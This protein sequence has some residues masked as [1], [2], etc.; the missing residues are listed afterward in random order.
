MQNE[1]KKLA[2]TD[3]QTNNRKVEIQWKTFKNKG[4]QFTFKNCPCKH[5]KEHVQGINYTC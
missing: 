1:W 3:K 2:E 5:C 4:R